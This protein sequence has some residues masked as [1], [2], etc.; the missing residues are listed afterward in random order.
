MA[1]RFEDIYSIKSYLDGDETAINII[2]VYTRYLVWPRLLSA[3]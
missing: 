3:D 2:M 1:Y